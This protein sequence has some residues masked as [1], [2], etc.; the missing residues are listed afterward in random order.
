MD[1][2]K[3]NDL[4]YEIRQLVGTFRDMGTTRGADTGQQVTRAFDRSSER[5]VRALGSL[6]ASMKG[7]NQ[8]SQARTREIE[9]FVRAIDQATD[10][11]Q[12][13]N[14]AAAQRAAADAEAAE[15]ARKRAAVEAEVAA[16][17]TWTQKQREAFDKQ[18][19]ATEARM[20]IGREQEAARQALYDFG[21]DRN[22]AQELAEAK[23][24]EMGS[25]FD[26]QKGLG[27][28]GNFV[29][30]KLGTDLVKTHMAV[31][32]FANVV[33]GAAQAV[34][35]LGKSLL[36][37]GGSVATG[38]NN[39]N[40]FNV[41]VDSVAG[42]IS[43]M[44]ASLPFVGA[45]MTL[46]AEGAKFMLGQIQRVSDSFN[47]VA[48]V[49]ALT[50]QGMDG[51]NRQFLQSGLTLEGYTKQVT[52]NS[53][54]LA[55]MGGTVA[56]GTERFTQ[57]TGSIIDQPIG[58]QLRSIGFSSEQ[59][60]DAAAGFLTQQ[61][62]L[63]R[64][65]RMS[66]DELRAGTIKYTKELDQIAKLTGMQREEVQKR[67]DAALSEQRFRA[68]MNE[69]ER[70]GRGDVAKQLNLFQAAVGQSAP[71]LAQGLRDIIAAGGAV[72]TDAARQ[73]F[74]LTG[75]QIVGI[76]Q[77]A[78]AGED[79]GS[80][81]QGLAQSVQ[82]GTKNYE[83]VA[84][85]ADVT[86]I[87]G[88]FA[89]ASDFASKGL[90]NF[91]EMLDKVRRDQVAGMEAPT[92]LTKGVVKSQQEMEQFSRSIN[93]FSIALMPKAASIVESFA[94][95][96]NDATK[97]IAKELG[98][99][100]PTIGNAAA[101]AQ[102]AARPMRG[103]RGARRQD[104]DRRAAAAP[105]GGAPM[106]PAERLRQARQPAAPTAGAP[107]AP[108]AAGIQPPPPQGTP[109]VESPGEQPVSGLPANKTLNDLFVFTAPSGTQQNFQGLD[110]QLRQRLIQAAVEYNTATGQKLQINSAKRSSGDQWRLW[111]E[112]VAAGR[113][114]RTAG[115]HPIAY[116][117]TSPHERGVAVDINNY[118]DPAARQAL[119]N[120]G[121]YAR[122]ADDPMHY[123]MARGGIARGPDSGYPA[124]LHGIEAVVPLPNGRSIPVEIKDKIN[125]AQRSLDDMRQG[126]L[127][128]IIAR[129]QQQVG[130]M[131][132]VVRDLGD[133]MRVDFEQ[134]S[135]R[136]ARPGTQAIDSIRLN[137]LPEM[138]DL[139]DRAQDIVTAGVERPAAQIPSDLAQQIG[140]E[141]S[142]AVESVMRQQA[143]VDQQSSSVLER[144][145]E[146]Q[147][148]S[149]KLSER[150]LRTSQG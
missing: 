132:A 102:E 31:M 21:R 137:L 125:I 53:Q 129:Q 121:L 57:L 96:L 29:S 93:A 94:T 106:S 58:L 126:G 30:G 83:K 25:I 82:T 97:K 138:Q 131:T 107:A 74:Q 8:S 80:S 47:A 71:G 43:K 135:R 60:A 70:T 65:Q 4:L 109:P 134:I 114:G 55:R 123:H 116:P 124:T 148:R 81:L 27:K 50:S 142:R 119:T 66:Q 7:Q 141:V 140:R 9:D 24:R 130:G 98:I 51:V 54:A 59:I 14:E 42:A 117:G 133:R 145:V 78:L 99:A 26:L 61:A 77:R 147:D 144:M 44:A 1:E 56:E 88:D 122:V 86:P 64:A 115:G 104:R 73:A 32:G 149:V 103:G 13:Q 63:G 11:A 143:A 75:G 72:T 12:E 36:S 127:A 23:I 49:G 39:F 112:S 95:T 85:F 20:R 111:E 5:L 69:L 33:G 48:Q 67:M 10:A 84:Q 15:E 146:L 120:A 41:V 113:K 139:F 79:V 101:Q 52:A 40:Q 89:Q 136:S 3:L 34:G 22:Y 62:R 68:K 76:A 92:E 108:A 19:R 37:L 28:F 38:F 128:R 105:G 16:R 100:L 90:N 118:R 6:A 110:N 46:A 150:L 91:A 45:A 18:V 87:I 2:Q 17:M 35:T